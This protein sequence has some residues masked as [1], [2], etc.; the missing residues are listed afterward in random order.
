MCP[1]ETEI[2]G[3]P[4]MR[5]IHGVCSLQKKTNTRCALYE[6]EIQ[7]T[8]FMRQIQGMPIRRKMSRAYPLSERYCR[9]SYVK[10]NGTAEDKPLHGLQDHQN[11]TDACNETDNNGWKSSSA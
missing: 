10:R 4:F 5:N 9:L 2:Q 1:S 8:P 7:G 11:K 3:V 6:A